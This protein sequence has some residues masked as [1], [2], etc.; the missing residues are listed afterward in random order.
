MFFSYSISFYFYLN[1]CNNNNNT[2][3]DNFLANHETK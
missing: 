2:M 3:L 1:N